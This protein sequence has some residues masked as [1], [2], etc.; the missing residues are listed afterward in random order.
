LLVSKKYEMTLLF[1]RKFIV[2]FLTGYPSAQLTNS[3]T[4]WVGGTDVG[5]QL[6]ADDVD[7]CASASISCPLAGGETIV[8]DVNLVIDAPVVGV[9][10]TIEYAMTNEN[11]NVLV[12]FRTDINVI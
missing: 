2:V 11:G 4:A 1:I 10:A 5:Y 7:A 9:L 12:C 3:V 6:P 8:Y